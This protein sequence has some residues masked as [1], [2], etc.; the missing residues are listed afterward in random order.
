MFVAMRA[1]SRDAY[2]EQFE[3]QRCITFRTVQRFGCLPAPLLCWFGLGS[4]PLNFSPPLVI[5]R[6]RSKGVCIYPSLTLGR[7]WGGGGICDFVMSLGPGWI[8]INE[9]RRRPHT[10]VDF[11]SRTP[12]DRG[13]V[14]IDRAVR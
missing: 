4:G 9:V 3:P 11:S 10:G 8:S 1:Y 7:A 6:L 14:S 5:G 13:F 12:A 2:A